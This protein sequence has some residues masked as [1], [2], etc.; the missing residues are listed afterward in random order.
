MAQSRD[1]EAEPLEKDIGS[2]MNFGSQK[3]VRT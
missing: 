3:E 1:I 2:G